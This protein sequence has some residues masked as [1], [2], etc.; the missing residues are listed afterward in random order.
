MKLYHESNIDIVQIDLAKCRPYKDFG[1]GFY[2]TE[3]E[4][5]ARKKARRV[6]RIYG[7]DP[8]VNVYEIRNDFMNSIDLSILDFGEV[9]S[10][11]WARFVMNN[12]NARFSDMASHSEMRQTRYHFIPKMQ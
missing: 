9:P 3:I 10:P 5:Q 1:Q 8:I 4:E 11:E 2:L 12:R 6:S 7:G